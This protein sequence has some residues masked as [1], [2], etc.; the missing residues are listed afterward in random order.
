[1]DQWSLILMASQLA[2]IFSVGEKAY[3]IR[4]EGPYANRFEI[5]VAGNNVRGP[6][7]LTVLNDQHIPVRI[8]PFE[9]SSLASAQRVQLTGLP[10]GKYIFN[11][12][13]TGKAGEK[14]FEIRQD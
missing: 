9:P 10:S 4:Q 2:G 6:V 3:T 1:M 13:L 8:I 12:S 14:A 7:I 11:F 5:S